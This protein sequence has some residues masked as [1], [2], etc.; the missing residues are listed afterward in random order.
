L[1]IAQTVS[2]KNMGTFA[3][4]FPAA[5]QSRRFGAAVHKK[6]FAELEGRA[7][8]LRAVE[9][10]VNRPD[11]GQTILAIAPEDRELFESRYHEIAAFM[12]IQVIEGGPERY[13]TVARALALVRD[14]CE[15]V[16]I[17]DAARPCLTTEL[18][19][20]VFDAAR[21]H[22]AA[23]PGN[24]VTDTLKRIDAEG[25]VLETIPRAGL[26]AVQTPQAF[27]RDL[28]TRAYAERDRLTTA[29]T[30]DAQLVEAIGHAV[31]V[32]EGSRYNLKITTAEDMPIAARFLRLLAQ[33]HGAAHHPH[34]FAEEQGVWGDPPAGAL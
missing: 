9:P 33:H 26:V 21:K 24:P 2:E 12:D 11:V 27:R 25:Q 7:V 8:W 31:H 18:I 3:V 32:V 6:I 16:A 10:F 15:Y 20:R 1:I 13:E 30:D 28:I 14:H 22:G 17:H 29:I 4:I 34:P 19:D 5:G 23:L